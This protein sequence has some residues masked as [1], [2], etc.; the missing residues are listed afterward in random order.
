MSQANEPSV[1]WANAAAAAGGKSGNSWFAHLAVDQ[2][3]DVSSINGVIYGGGRGRGG[4]E[5]WRDNNL[6]SPDWPSSPQHLLPV[7]L[8]CRRW[9]H[10]VVLQQRCWQ[11]EWDIS[12]S[13]ALLGLHAALTEA[14]LLLPYV[15]I[16]GPCTVLSDLY[17]YLPSNRTQCIRSRQLSTD[18]YSLHFFLWCICTLMLLPPVVFLMFLSIFNI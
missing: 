6:F 4:S 18:M 15:P 8:L 10:F 5:S 17:F 1:K 11:A 12:R 7:C 13:A 2:P 16:V 9:E 14:F 3:F